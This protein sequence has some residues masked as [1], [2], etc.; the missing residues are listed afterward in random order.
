MGDGSMAILSRRDG[1][2]GVETTDD[3]AGGTLCIV[4]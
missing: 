1:R 4:P 2:N 3:R